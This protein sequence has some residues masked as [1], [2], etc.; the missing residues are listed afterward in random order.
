MR[1]VIMPD[2]KA[3]YLNLYNN[4]TDT[5]ERLKQ[6]QQEAEEK[7]MSEEPVVVLYPKAQETVDADI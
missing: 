3:L 5:I 6:A 7:Y 4:V 1:G 2:Y